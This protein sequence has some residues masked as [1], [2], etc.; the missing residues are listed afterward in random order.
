MGRLTTLEYKN[1]VKLRC[2]ILDYGKRCSQG[3]RC[4]IEETK[5]IN[6][7]LKQHQ[8]TTTRCLKEYI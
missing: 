7:D 4:I 1:G 2:K 6:K 5:R 8:D 3:R